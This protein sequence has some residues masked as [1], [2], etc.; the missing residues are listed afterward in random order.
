MGTQ[1]KTRKLQQAISEEFD[2]YRAA[3]EWGLIEPIIIESHSDLVSAANWRDKIE[4]YQHQISNLISFCRR[5]PVALLADDVGL[6]KTIS[7]GLISSELMSRGRVSKILIVCPKLIMPQWEEELKVKFNIPSVIASGNKITKAMLPNGRGALITTYNSARLYLDD[8]VKMGFEFL[9]LDEA[10]KLRNLHGSGKAPVVGKMFQKALA[11][12]DFKY[13]LMLTATPIQNRLW[14]MYSLVDL[15]ASARGHQNPFGT[16]DKFITKFVAD[17]RQ[18]ARKLKPQKQEEFRSIVY[19]HMSRIRRADAKLAFPE[20]IVQLNGVK[21]TK[22]ELDLIDVIAKPIQKLNRLS[23][24]SIAQALISSPHA[25]LTQLQSMAKKNTIPKSLVAQVRT[26]VE[27]ISI[28]A[29]QKGLETLVDKLRREKP[30]DW[31]VVIFTTRRETQSTIEAFLKN[32]G[33]ESGII[34]G[35]S[36]SKNVGTIAK[37]KSDPPQL[38]V[39]ISTE[40]G[41]EGVNLQAANVLVN[42]DLPWNPMVVEQRIGR[43][44]RLASAHKNVC[45]FN[46]IL[47]GTFE[48]YIVGRL[49]EKLQMASQAIGDVDALLDAAGIN[50]EGNEGFEENIREL[51][52]AALAGRDVEEAIKLQEKNIVSAKVQLKKA[53]E[54]LNEILG[55]DGPPPYNGPS[56]PK[57][58]KQVRSIDLP[59]F[60][61]RALESLGGKMTPADQGQFLLELDETKKVISFESNKDEATPGLIFGPGD[62]DFERIVS[63]ISEVGRRNIEDLDIGAA[64]KIDKLVR[65]WPKT[66]KGKYEKHTVEEITPCFTGTALVRIRVTVAHDSFERLIEVNCAPGQDTVSQKGG[67]EPL[68]KFISNPEILGISSEFLLEQTKQEPGIA[69]FCRF[70]GERFAHEVQNVGTNKRLRKKLEGDFLPRFHIELV[71][72]KGQF[73]RQV[74]AKISYSLGSKKDYSSELLMIPS[75]N[76]ITSATKMGTC[77]VTKQIAP[78]DCLG[79]CA[80]TGLTVMKHLLEKSALSGREALSEKLV[81]C[82]LSKKRLFP[83]EV[84]KSAVSGKF[85]EK[86]L[87]KKSEISGKLAEPEYFEKCSFTREEALKDE[88]MASQVSGKKFRMDHVMKSE[89]SGKVGHPKEFIACAETNYP[90]IPSE[91]VQCEVTGKKVLPSELVECSVTQKKVLKSICVTSSIS[92]K[93]I[94]KNKAIKSTTG[95]F[96]SPQEAMVCDWSHQR[97]HPEDAAVCLITG[98]SFNRELIDQERGY[99]LNLLKALSGSVVK[100]DEKRSWDSIVNQEN[101]I[102]GTY[103]K[104]V[105]S[106]ERSPKGTL[107]SVCIKLSSRFGLGVK[108]AGFIYSLKDKVVVGQ[109]RIGKRKGSTWKIE[110]EKEPS[111]S[112][113]QKAAS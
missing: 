38:H 72:F 2:L 41:S 81:T 58:P 52:V 14:D 39:I 77:A 112:P 66:F 45:V 64:P 42:Y 6:G 62:P 37:F 44:Q 31:R 21:P 111:N 48:E 82:H 86:S 76:E 74:K 25:L 113:P 99:F 88:L 97:I 71:G 63:R 33:I 15:L 110:T 94:I 24:I 68:P 32:K 12:R 106:V 23:Q 19:S 87:L 11:N 53:E 83:D 70:Y 34:N 51:V 4:P 7:A 55:S 29:K 30:K 56:T 40:A 78:E 102:F 26:I 65:G 103:K 105:E 90:L 95:K 89:V 60:V 93:W 54:N 20:R 96:C 50:E 109:I 3:L 85:V 79:L 80:I 75:K 84:E 91:A 104:T 27:S 13:V 100:K 47:K 1:L 9:I 10:H 5:L 108:Y 43:V 49:M 36:G 16:K 17:K 22:P 46:L 98:L 101:I 61:K 18:H 73:Y 69:E 92:K 59:T 67:L 35:D 107:V 8:I 28:T 57:L